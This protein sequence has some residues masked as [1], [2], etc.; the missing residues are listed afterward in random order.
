MNKLIWLT[1]DAIEQA[2]GHGVMYEV[3]K[4]NTSYLRFDHEVGAEAKWSF[5]TLKTN[6][7]WKAVVIGFY[8]TDD[9]KGACESHHAYISNIMKE[10]YDDGFSDGHYEG[11]GGA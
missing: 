10:E 7:N 4:L 1:I 3:E 2:S 9:A 5:N 6:R 8:N 11:A